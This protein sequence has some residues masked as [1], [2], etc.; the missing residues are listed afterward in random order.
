MAQLWESS[1]CQ[2]RS[3][4]LAHESMARRNCSAST[5]LSVAMRTPRSMCPCFSNSECR[6][7]GGRFALQLAGVSASAT[8]VVASSQR[9]IRRILVYLFDRGTGK[10]Y[11]DLQ[12]FPS[13]A[14]AKL[15]NVGHKA[16]AADAR[17]M[18]P[19]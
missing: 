15:G 3:R 8:Q 17:S 9:D 14:S 16:A 6:S 12:T 10:H 13:Q 19:D 1:S 5:G 4:I 2:S 7:Q 18:H 11:T